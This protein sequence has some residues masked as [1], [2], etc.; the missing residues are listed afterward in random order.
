MGVVA[1]VTH[2][3]ADE[4][5]ECEPVA[6]VANREGGGF[7]LVEDVPLSQADSAEA[8]HLHAELWRILSELRSLD[9]ADADVSADWHQHLNDFRPG[10]VSPSE[11]S[12]ALS[13]MCELEATDQL[14]LLESVDTLERLIF[15]KEAF[16]EAVSIKAARA[17]LAQLQFAW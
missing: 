10:V 16:R 1:R 9:K 15:L 11:F 12:L 6:R 4:I 14:R 3:A 17:S 5:I 7:H 13:S 8:E 2:V